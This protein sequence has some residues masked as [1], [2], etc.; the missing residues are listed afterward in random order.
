MVFA[1]SDRVRSP[2]GTPE[3]L[4]GGCEMTHEQED[5]KVLE[6]VRAFRKREAARLAKVA[7]DPRLCNKMFDEDCVDAEA[8]FDSKG[9]VRK[10]LIYA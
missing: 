1:Y 4:D 5:K 2:L 10:E 9:R 7:A 6:I 3:S 8:T